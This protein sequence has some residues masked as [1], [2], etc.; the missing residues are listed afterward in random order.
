MNENALSLQEN[1]LYSLVIRYR[2]FVVGSSLN[3]YMLEE[4]NGGSY[5]HTD[6]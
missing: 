3:I 1:F 6:P 2:I 4:N 5:Q